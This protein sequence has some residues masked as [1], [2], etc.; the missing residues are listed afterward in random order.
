MLGPWGL[1]VN[2]DDLWGDDGQEFVVGGH[3][4][5]A[6]SHEYRL[7]HACYHATLGNWPLRLASL[8][9]IAEMVLA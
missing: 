3:R 8:R 7:L 1:L 4:L 5:R 2:L 9:D 6:L